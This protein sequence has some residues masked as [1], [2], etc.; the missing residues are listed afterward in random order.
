MMKNRE[1]S[2]IISYNNIGYTEEKLL[3]F[4][5]HSLLRHYEVLA[6]ASGNANANANVHKA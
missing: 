4:E 3:L 2:L 5:N 6:S 1:S